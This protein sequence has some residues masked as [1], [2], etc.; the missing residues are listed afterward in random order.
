MSQPNALPRTFLGA[1]GHHYINAPGLFY[2]AEVTQGRPRTYKE[3]PQGYIST[4]DAATLLCITERACRSLL[5][6]HGVP[7]VK[8]QAPTAAHAKFWKSSA[9][10]QVL[11]N[12]LPLL[13]A[14]PKG[15]IPAKKAC[16]LL[17]VTR[18]TLTRY[19]QAGLLH[20]HAFRLARNPGQI[21]VEKWYRPSQV[22]A[23][24]ARLKKSR[25]RELAQRQERYRRMFSD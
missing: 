24:A 5:Q 12:R 2:P 10:Q 22:K 6:R 20:E 8:V 16:L 19:T 13:T 3:P 23:L 25:E 21:R 15:L 17:M 1:D 14:A 18:S 9:I 4:R 7:S 11:E